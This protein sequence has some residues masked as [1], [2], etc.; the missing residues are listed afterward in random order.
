MSGNYSFIVSDAL[1]AM[2]LLKTNSV[3]LLLTSPPYNVG[4]EYEV[5]QFKSQDQYNILV[6]KIAKKSSRVVSKTGSVCWQ[7]GVSIKNGSI[8]PLDYIA[9]EAFIKSGF[10]LRNR[11]IWRFGSGLHAQRRLSGRYEVLLWFTK[12]DDYTFNLD[13]IRV[14]QKYPGKRAKILKEGDIPKFTGNP[15]GK[16]PTDFWEFEPGKWFDTETVWEFPN[17]KANHPEK[18]IHPCQFPIELVQRC[19]LALTNKKD[20]VFDPFAGV[21]STLV[22]A[23]MHGRKPLGVDKELKYAE[24][25][26]NRIKSLET[27][28]LPIRPLGTPIYSPPTGKLTTLPKEWEALRRSQDGEKTNT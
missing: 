19:V 1:D 22:G 7:C 20:M 9:Y 18:T 2:D 14:P 21:G 24:I 15:L 27:E 28:G 3:D 12:T 10:T 8:I 6:N 26:I 17:V 13:S 11:I 5:G 23:L 4:K 25:T 16:N